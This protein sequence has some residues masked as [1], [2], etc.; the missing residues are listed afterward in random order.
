MISYPFNATVVR[1][2]AAAVIAAFFPFL[3]TSLGVANT[4]K[5]GV[6]PQSVIISFYVGAAVLVI[7]SLFTI[8]R[9]HEYDPETYA[10]YH[11]IKE[12]IPWSHP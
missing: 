5:K 12:S 11:G 3:L 9:V 10:R 1:V 7:T 6:V 2:S 8:F 4:A